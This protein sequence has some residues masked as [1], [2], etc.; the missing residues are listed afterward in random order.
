M[1]VVQVGVG[2][3]LHASPTPSQ[4]Y[5]AGCTPTEARWQQQQQQRGL[6]QVLSLSCL[7]LQ[8][9]L[10]RSHPP[11]MRSL[12]VLLLQQEPGPAG[13]AQGLFN[14]QQQQQ[15]QP[16]HHSLLQGKRLLLLLLQRQHQQQG[17]AGLAPGL[18]CLGP[19]RL[20]HHSKRQQHRR[21][22]V[23]LVLQGLAGLVQ[24]AARLLCQGASCQASSPPYSRCLGPAPAPPT[25]TRCWSTGGAVGASTPAR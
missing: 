24:A 10:Q 23:P 11:G 19:Q 12:L 7:E 8:Q 25:C 21:L 13:L 17:P 16:G 15:Q 5:L 14:L 2:W 3:L 6:Q 9:P 18:S 22:P 20:V 1:A 4:A